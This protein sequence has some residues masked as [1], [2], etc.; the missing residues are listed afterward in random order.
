MAQGPDLDSDRMH[1]QAERLSR[2]FDLLHRKAEDRH[3]S[4]YRLQAKYEDCQRAY[5]TC[6]RMDCGDGN[7]TTLQPVAT[8]IS[9]RT[10]RPLNA[11]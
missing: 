3:M 4:E 2:S 1:A 6:R 8:E 10:S 11:R 5:V 7:G 9:L